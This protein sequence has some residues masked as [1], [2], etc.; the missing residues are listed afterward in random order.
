MSDEW[1]KI[2][3]TGKDYWIIKQGKSLE[4]VV[5]TKPQHMFDNGHPVAHFSAKTKEEAI[6]KGVELAKEHGLYSKHLQHLR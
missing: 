2:I 4:Y 3:Y 1:N 5:M 6:N